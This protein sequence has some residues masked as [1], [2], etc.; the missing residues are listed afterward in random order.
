VLIAPVSEQIPWY[1]GIL[2][3]I[4]RFWGLE[5][6][7]RAKRPLRCSHFSSN[8]LRRLS[9]KIFWGTANF[10]TVSGIYNSRNVSVHFSHTCCPRFGRDLFSPMNFQKR[11][12]NMPECVK[13][14]WVCNL[15]T[16]F[17]FCLRQSTS[18]RGTKSLPRARHRY[19]LNSGGGLLRQGRPSPPKLQAVLAVGM[20]RVTPAKQLR[21]PMTLP[22]YQVTRI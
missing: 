19:R 10:K 4:L 14:M 7:L 22:A 9:A 13:L 2:Q 16:P 15:P 5:T 17:K 20:I 21:E 11:G 6:R 18:A 8:S 12:H 1:Q 3:G